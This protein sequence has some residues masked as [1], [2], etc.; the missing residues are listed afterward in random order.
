MWLIY[1]S[2][3]IWGGKSHRKNCLVL[4]LVV[5]NFCL[6]IWYFFFFFSHTAWLCMILFPWPGIEP[7]SLRWKHQVL[8]IGPPG[9]SFLVLF[10]NSQSSHEDH[11]LW[12]Q[13]K[14]V[15][16]FIVFF[17][18][19]GIWQERAFR[20]YSAACEIGWGM[21]PL[22]NICESIYPSYVH[23]N[24]GADRLPISGYFGGRLSLFMLVWNF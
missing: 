7:G 11:F 18:P 13:W 24:W 8:T 10:F 1:H 4:L 6:F 19:S 5:I 9:I 22:L 16:L 14:N 3:T 21:G 15:A 23:W 17:V 20:V 12:L 2:I